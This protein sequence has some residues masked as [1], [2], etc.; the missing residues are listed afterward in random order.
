M[1]K[2]RKMKKYKMLILGLSILAGSQHAYAVDADA[3]P[4][5]TNRFVFGAGGFFA[6]TDAVIGAE[7]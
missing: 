2:W 3:N 6:N 4:I 5:F 1:E 7:W